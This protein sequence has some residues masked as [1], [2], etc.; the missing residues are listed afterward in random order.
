[1]GVWMRDLVFIFERVVEGGTLDLA[2]RL[3]PLDLARR[4]TPLDLA[5][6]LTPLDLEQNKVYKLRHQGHRSKTP[7]KRA[8]DVSLQYLLIGGSKHPLDVSL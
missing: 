7:L 5:R 8:I 2:R 1:M 4:L 6:R 3:T